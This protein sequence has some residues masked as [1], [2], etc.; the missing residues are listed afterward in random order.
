[1]DDSVIISMFFERSESAISALDEKYGSL[2][3]SVSMRILDD[4]RDAEECVNDAYLGVWKAIPPERPDPLSAFL[5]KIVRNLSINRYHR[6]TAAKRRSTYTAALSELEDVLYSP[7]SVESSIDEKELIR[8]IEDF[9]D[10]LTP[11]NRIIF[12]RRYWLCE[13]YAET[14]RFVGI[15]EKNVSVKL[16]RIRARLKKYL[17]ERGFEI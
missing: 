4:L 12:L 7:E 14:A 3:R 11:D 5:I 16:S 6:N 2:C 13:S 10:S 9:L 17:L 8:T 15:S 1:M